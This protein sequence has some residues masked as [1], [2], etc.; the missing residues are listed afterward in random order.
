MDQTLVL[1]SMKEI[2]DSVK[3]SSLPH[4]RRY[5][6]KQNSMVLFCVHVQCWTKSEKD[7]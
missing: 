1:K 3:H 6:I 5:T 4:V 7:C 2:S